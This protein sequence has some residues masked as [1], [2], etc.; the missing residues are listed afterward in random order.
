MEFS[1]AK[2]TAS[3]LGFIAIVSITTYFILDEKDLDDSRIV[4]K[5]FSNLD[6]DDG[7]GDIPTW[8]NTYGSFKK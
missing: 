8:G 7:T 1:T 5:Y 6:A 4:S 2:W 3:I